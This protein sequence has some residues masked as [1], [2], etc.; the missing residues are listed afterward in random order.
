MFM[1][2]LSY[3]SAN[4]GEMMGI[5]DQDSFCRRL[6]GAVNAGRRPTDSGCSPAVSI[7]TAMAEHDD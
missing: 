5:A 4:T 3:A 1:F 2:A 7:R 6:S